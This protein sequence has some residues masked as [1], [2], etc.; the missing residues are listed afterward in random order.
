[1]TNK[2]NEPYPL[3]DLINAADPAYVAE[4]KLVLL[5][6]WAEP[7]GLGL[8]GVTENLLQVVSAEQQRLLASHQPDQSYLQELQT[9]CTG[10]QAIQAA[11]LKMDL[12][13]ATVPPTKPKRASRKTNKKQAK[14][15]HPLSG[16]GFTIHPL[17]SATWNRHEAI[18]GV[19]PSDVQLAADYRK[20]QWW[21]MRV[22]TRAVLNAS[23]DWTA[24]VSSLTPMSSVLK[25]TNEFLAKRHGLS[26]QAIGLHLRRMS[27]NLHQDFLKVVI[28]CCKDDLDNGLR[29]MIHL[30]R[31]IDEW[32]SSDHGAQQ[33]RQA[34]VDAFRLVAEKILDPQLIRTGTSRKGGGSGPRSPFNFGFLGRQRTIQRGSAPEELPELDD[35]IEDEEVVEQPDV[36]D[37]PGDAPRGTGF[38]LVDPAHLKGHLAKA[39]AQ[40]HYLA[41]IAQGFRWDVNTLT[42]SERNTL[43]KT[44]SD[45]VTASSPAKDHYWWSKAALLCAWVCGRKFQEVLTLRYLHQKDLSLPKE[46][47]FGV[48]ESNG[49]YYWRWPLRLANRVEVDD[50]THAIPRVNHVLIPDTTGLVE[51]L[52]KGHRKRCTTHTKIFTSLKSSLSS[53]KNCCEKL[54]GSAID[55]PIT[56]AMLTRDLRITLLNAAPDKTIAWMLAGTVADASEPRMFYTAYTPQELTRWALHAHEVMKLNFAPVQQATSGTV[57]AKWPSLY[58][59]ARFLPELQAL[60]TVCRIVREQAARL[61]PHDLL[62]PPQVQAGRKSAASA[63][64]TAIAGDSSSPE[65]QE[66]QGKLAWASVERWRQ[67][68]DD[69]VLWVWIVQALQT[70]QRATRSPSSLYTQW[71]QDHKR[72]WVSLEDKRTAD[73]DE[74]RAGVI[75]PMLVNAF[76]LLTEVQC[77]YR[78]RWMVQK[79]KPRKSGDA[80]NKYLSKNM[81][82]GLMV[83]AG[84]DHPT[85]LTPKWAQTGILAKTGVKFPTNFNRS[86]LRRAL[87]QYGLNGDELDAF[88]GHG[89]MADR[90]HDRHSLFDTGK[91]FSRLQAA[92]KTW[93]KELNLQR[94]DLPKRVRPGLNEIKKGKRTALQ[95]FKFRAQQIQNANKKTRVSSGP[96]VS[97][98]DRWRMFVEKTLEHK[99]GPSNLKHL[100]A[101]H[102]MLLG[103]E[104]DFAK[105]V[106]GLDT[107]L[108]LPVGPLQPKAMEAFVNLHRDAAKELESTVVDWVA[109]RLIKRTVAAHGMNLSYN[110]CQAMD[111]RMPTMRV[112][113]TPHARVSPFTPERISWACKAEHWRR[114][115]VNALKDNSLDQSKVRLALC[116]FLNATV[117]PR[118]WLACTKTL[119][120]QAQKKPHL[121]D[122]TYVYTTLNNT[123]RL[124]R[125][126]GFMNAMSATGGPVTSTALGSL[127]RV[128]EVYREVFKRSVPGVTANVNHWILGLKFFTQ[129]HLP[130]LITAHLV[131][132]LNDQSVDGPLSKLMGWREAQPQRRPHR[133]SA[134]NSEDKDEPAVFPQID[135]GVDVDTTIP[136][137]WPPEL[138]N[139]GTDAEKWLR[140]FLL[141]MVGDQSRKNTLEDLSDALFEAVDEVPSHLRR[142]VISLVVELRHKNK[143]EPDETIN[144]QG[145]QVDRHVVDFKTYQMVLKTLEFRR[146]TSSNHARLERMRLLVV[147]AFRLGMRRREILNLRV[148]DIDLAG[149]GR[150]HI[151]A[152]SGHT[153]KTS[154]SRRS[155]PIHPLLNIQERQWLEQACQSACRAKKMVPSA[156]RLF[157]KT[158]HDTL[159][160]DAIKLLKK[161]GGDNYLKLHHL[162]HSF[163]SWMTLQV[164]FARHPEWADVFASYPETYSEMQ[165]SPALIGTLLKPELIAGDFW[166]VPRLLGHSSYEVSVTNYVHTLDLATALFINHELSDVV[167]PARHQVHLLSRRINNVNQLR[168]SF[169]GA[170]QVAATQVVAPVVQAATSSLSSEV[171]DV[172]MKMLKATSGGLAGSFSTGST[173]LQ[174]QRLRN[175]FSQRHASGLPELL[176][177]GIDHL[178]HVDVQLL[179]TLGQAY[180]TDE[181]VMFLFNRR[182][183]TQKTLQSGQ[184][185]LANLLR[186]LKAMGLTDEHVT[187]WKFR[188]AP[189]ADHSLIWDGIITT[190]GF[191]VKRG[192]LKGSFKAADALGVSVGMKKARCSPFMGTLLSALAAIN[193]S[194]P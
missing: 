29:D 39:K 119:V 120:D 133:K 51:K 125:R 162:R 84:R 164:V 85:Y 194:A 111:P 53:I 47:L 13:Y 102:A 117:E 10:L 105:Y 112:A 56:E 41:M 181:P 68:H 145:D 58:A 92:L 116:G 190:H 101:W 103:C 124:R 98:F 193:P 157:P 95:V 89:S 67:W 63:P 82:F 148:G 52:I 176:L 48:G 127:T 4:V 128:R 83:F 132:S 166:I 7:K 182:R 31:R 3:A 15:K 165:N 59:G 12:A 90:V 60:K 121:F 5:G 149:E 37:D 130:P 192:K 87:S 143:L 33:H 9:W 96:V 19:S 27:L 73:R 100:K 45:V 99:G 65:S 40:S 137:G 153:L 36:E 80:L 118:R 25:A 20:L 139:S 79:K 187:F 114:A 189:D 171:S 180:W 1:M 66:I 167:V 16:H 154:F 49:V 11:M 179:T 160:R 134:H 109:Q 140:T 161:I 107:D 78:T 138:A 135:P 32:I 158:E 38:R 152:Y 2:K 174:H 108:T 177:Q 106:L 30:G 123:G 136:F 147:L 191:S 188:G 14:L 159:C 184:Q 22:H 6:L 110:L 70:S 94:I 75:P 126:R 170:R 175:W 146:M 172:L 151:R 183:F 54:P 122:A 62:K 72:L 168:K 93:Q 178:D 86:A 185:D 88:M 57:A 44:L 104:L 69:V 42:E 64:S 144:S 163:A 76:V 43:L 35:W 17:Y 34:A 141:T 55:R 173:G 81:P 23:I 28:D 46:G 97:D 50:F 115:C 26:F 142:K 150:I 155:L 21:W 74:S 61:P 131:G 169:L 186:I 77:M 24:Y 18:N 91:Y 8:K 71:L 113:I 129:M 156:N